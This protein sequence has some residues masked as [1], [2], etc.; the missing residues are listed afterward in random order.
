VGQFEFRLLLPRIRKFK[1]THNI[2]A[3]DERGNFFAAEFGVASRWAADFYAA[4]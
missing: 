3:E 4:A 2:L 1:L